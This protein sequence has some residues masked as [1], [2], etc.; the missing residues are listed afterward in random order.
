M[1]TDKS[2][3]RA[4]WLRIIWW[5]ALNC[6]NW[7][8]AICTCAKGWPRMRSSLDTGADHLSGWHHILPNFDLSPDPL[9]LMR[10]ADC[11]ISWPMSVGGKT[12]DPIGAWWVSCSSAPC[13]PT[14][15][16]MLNVHLMLKWFYVYFCVDQ[17]NGSKCKTERV[18][19]IMLF[20]T[21]LKPI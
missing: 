18:R 6:N 5:R 13:L 14:V 7:C 1:L 15:D 10:L 20:G 3:Q 4:H 12:F 8:L 16:S 19:E 11:I 21:C 9:W 17:W 2:Q